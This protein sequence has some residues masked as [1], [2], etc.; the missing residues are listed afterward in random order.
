MPTISLGAADEQVVPVTPYMWMTAPLSSQV[1]KVC[2]DFI[3]SQGKSKLAM[4]TDTKNA[5]AVSGHDQTNNILNQTGL[6]LITDDT[7][8]TTQTNFAPQL[9]KLADPNPDFLLVWA[10]CA[11][12]VRI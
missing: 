3:K 10:T 7:I 1:A 6:H 9:A 11:P 5:Y 2:V 8:D 12:P 4:L